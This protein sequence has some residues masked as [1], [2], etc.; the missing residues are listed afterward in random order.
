MAECHHTLA[1][2]H[3]SHHCPTLV[4]AKV[5]FEISANGYEQVVGILQQLP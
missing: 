4:T 3:V 1:K 2:W 5:Q